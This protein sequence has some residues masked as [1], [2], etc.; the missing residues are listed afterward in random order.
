M[1]QY[2]SH[3]KCESN[4]N[5]YKDNNFFLVHVISFRSF[6]QTFFRFLISFFTYTTTFSTMI[7]HVKRMLGIYVWT[8]SFSLPFLALVI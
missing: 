6:Q 3:K 1:K 2:H 5:L 7:V 4:H 8:K